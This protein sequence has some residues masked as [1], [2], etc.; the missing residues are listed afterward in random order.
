MF[1]KLILPIFGLLY[2]YDAWMRLLVE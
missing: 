2:G 1:F